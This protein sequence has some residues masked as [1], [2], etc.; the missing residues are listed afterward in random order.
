M[1]HNINK[2]WVLL[3]HVWPENQNQKKIE[4]LSRNTSESPVIEI[5][6]QH[7]SCPSLFLYSLILEAS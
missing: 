3:A 6:R 2:W 4:T 5:N 1:E 7:I